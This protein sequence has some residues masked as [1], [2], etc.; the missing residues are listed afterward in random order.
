MSQT[1]H[2]APCVGPSAAEQG[3]HWHLVKTH[4]GKQGMLQ[5]HTASL[6]MFQDSGSPTAL[7]LPTALYFSLFCASQFD[8]EQGHEL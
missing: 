1:K 6:Q 5:T 3:A 2:T 7:L 4:P 8:E